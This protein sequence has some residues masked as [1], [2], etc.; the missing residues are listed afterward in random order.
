[1]FGRVWWWCDMTVVRRRDSRLIVFY[2]SRRGMV[3]AFAKEQEPLRDREVWIRAA[4]PT[5]ILA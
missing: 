1:M 5:V 2:T 4:R 3:C